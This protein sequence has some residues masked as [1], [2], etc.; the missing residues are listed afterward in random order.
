MLENQFIRVN[1]QPSGIPVNNICKQY[2]KN[3]KFVKRK[4]IEIKQRFE[5]ALKTVL[6]KLQILHVNPEFENTLSWQ[7]VNNLCHSEWICTL[8]FREKYVE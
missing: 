5:H 3:E 2:L 1:D 7:V 8:N 4:G 6:Q